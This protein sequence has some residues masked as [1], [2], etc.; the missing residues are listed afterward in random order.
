MKRVYTAPDPLLA[1]VLRGA[2]EAAGVSAEVRRDALFSTRGETPITFDTLPEVWVGDETD[3]AVVAD[4]IREFESRPHA[5]SGP[6]WLCPV[7]GETNEPQFTACWKCS[8]PN[9]EPDTQNPKPL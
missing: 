5:P 8:G 3:E 1:H 9:P 4:V 6:T 2:L 7:C